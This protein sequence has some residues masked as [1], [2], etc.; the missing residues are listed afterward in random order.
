SVFLRNLKLVQSTSF[1][2]AAMQTGA[3]W[4]DRTA[5]IVGGVGGALLGCLGALIARQ[6]ATLRRECRARADRRRR[7]IRTGRACRRRAAAAVRSVVC[8]P[9]ARCAGGG[10]LPVSSPPLS[11]S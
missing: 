8:A 11:R 3:W 2:G 1:D 9:A 6:G 7:G 5:G 4:S 10:N